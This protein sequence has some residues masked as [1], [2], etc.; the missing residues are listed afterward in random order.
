DE[1]VKGRVPKFIEEEHIEKEGR[2]T[3]LHTVKVPLFDEEDDAFGLLGFV[4]DITTLKDNERELKEAK[5]AAEAASKAKGEFLANMSHEIRTPMNGVIGMTSLLLDTPLNHEQ[6]DYVDTIRTSGDSLLT[7]IND[8]L[9]FSKIESGKLELEEQPFYLRNCV[10]EVLDLVA[11]KAAGKKLELAYLIEANT[12]ETIIGDVTRLRQILLNL[13][14]NAI[15]FTD[16]GEVVLSVNAKCLSSKKGEYELHFEVRDTGIGIPKDRIS[17]LFR[18]FSQ[19]D[20]STTRKYGGTGLGLAI[21]MQLSNLMGG[22]MWVESEGIPGK[23]SQFHFTIKARH[24][25]NQKELKENEALH[26]LAGKRVLIVDD[27]ETNRLILLQYAKGWKMDA[28]LCEGG[29]EALKCI[30]KEAP[31]DIAILDMQMPEMDGVQLAKNLRKLE[32]SKELP[33]IMLTSLG[34]QVDKKSS[35]FEAL[36]NKPIKPAALVNVLVGIFVK[37][38]VLVKSQDRKSEFDKSIGE[39]NPLRILLAEDNVV[40]QKVAQRMLGRIGY[41]IDIAA[42]GQEAIESLS[43]QA[44]DVILMDI[45]MPEMDGMEATKYIRSRWAADK[46]PYIIAMTA[47]A[48][49]GDKEKYLAIGM[50]DY[51]SKPV[52]VQ[53]LVEALAKCKP[54]KV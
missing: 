11:H 32:K 30:E 44:Y 33:L 18:S 41:R 25:K 49:Q 46:Q 2:K 28:V 34:N 53:E 52:R 36:L 23:G 17:R 26:K 42:N 45:Q 12:P 40:N 37:Q 22:K 47:N 16:K 31:F 9:D 14:N 4:H 50:N 19:V 21:S 48:L 43:R 20:A 1:V 54:L 27:N 6:H 3:F 39:K 10:E 38:P 7:I 51:V 13:L 24:N 29:K 5:N 15:K 35:E 8:I